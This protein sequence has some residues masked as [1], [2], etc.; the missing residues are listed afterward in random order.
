MSHQTPSHPAPQGPNQ[1]QYGAQPPFQT[2]PPGW[3]PPKPPKKPFFKRTWVIVT[4]AVLAVFIIIGIFSG[5]GNNTTSTGGGATE[6]AATSAPATSAPATQP[7]TSAKPTT[8]KA[9]STTQPP[10][11]TTCTG[12][13]NDPC[14]VKLGVAFTV[15]KHQMGKGWKLKTAEFSGTQLAG[16]VTNVADEASTAFFTVKFLKGN[17]VVANFQCSS[18]ELES[19]Q[20]EDI[21]CYNMSDTTRTLKAGSY[22]KITAEA[23]F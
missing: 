9:P 18:S 23:D 14:V 8:T 17:Q 22:N 19:H 7:K 21:E 20:S 10:A 1:P 13:R 16:T 11:E 2:P 4:G 6:T 5:G 3:Q 12:N 15:G